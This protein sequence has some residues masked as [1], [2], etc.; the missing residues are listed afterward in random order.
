[1]YPIHHFT[2]F[3]EIL[4]SLPKLVMKFKFS[5]VLIHNKVQT[6]QPPVDFVYLINL[7]NFFFKFN[8]GNN[9]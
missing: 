7:P 8:I 2:Y 5:T 9:H 4:Y 6:Y 1:M 3:I